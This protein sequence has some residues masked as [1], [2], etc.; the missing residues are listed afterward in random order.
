LL[1]WFF[2]QDGE[3]IESGISFWCFDCV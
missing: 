1:S 2:G 3:F